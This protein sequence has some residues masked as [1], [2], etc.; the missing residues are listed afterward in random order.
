MRGSALAALAL[1]AFSAQQTDAAQGWR[2]VTLSVPK[3]AAT[4]R[5]QMP[6]LHVTLGRVSRG[7]TVLVERPDGSLI[8]S[9]SPFGIVP[10]HAAGTYTVPLQ[11][12]DIATGKVTVRLAVALSGENTRAPTLSE[13]PSV[14]LDFVAVAK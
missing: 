12:S 6:V 14:S 1:L 2:D 3:T 10:G 4:E 9:V 7:T 8:G 13:V 5:A 11:A